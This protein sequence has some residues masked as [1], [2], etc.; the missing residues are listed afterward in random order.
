MENDGNA[1][2]SHSLFHAFPIS[3]HFP[4][5]PLLGIQFKALAAGQLRQNSRKGSCNSRERSSPSTYCTYSLLRI[6]HLIG[7][8]FGCCSRASAAMNAA[9]YPHGK[10]MAASPPFLQ[11]KRPSA[12][13]GPRWMANSTRPPIRPVYCHSA[14]KAPANQAAAGI[15]KPRI[16]G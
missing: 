16:P 5:F 4:G 6:Q 14:A 3:T 1:L 8:S 13:Y 9:R 10:A 12:C 7:L 15:R 11:V 2:E